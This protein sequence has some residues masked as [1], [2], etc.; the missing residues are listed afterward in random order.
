MTRIVELFELTFDGVTEISKADSI[1]EVTLFQVMKGA[2]SDD[3]CSVNPCTNGGTC[4][5]TWNDYHCECPKGYKGR[6]CSEKEFCHWYRC[7]IEASKCISLTDGYECV[8]NATF[9]G[10][11]STVDYTP[12]FKTDQ[13]VSHSVVA[14]FRTKTNGTVMQVSSGSS[15]IRLT[16]LSSGEMEIE[17]PES[18]DVTR[19]YVYGSSLNN[20]IW[21]TVNVTFGDGGV[22]YATLDGGEPGQLTLDSNVDLI[23]FVGASTV[24]VGASSSTTTGN[25]RDLYE[26]ENQTTVSDIVDI[27]TESLPL[28]RAEQTDNRADHFRGCIGEVRVAGVLLPFF[29]ESE[30]VNSTAGM[31]FI[32]DRISEVSSG[33]CV[34]CYENECQNG[35]F[36]DRPNEVFDCSCAAGFEGSTCG[37]NIDECV[38]SNCL[39]GVC[40]D[41]IANYTCNCLNG[42]TGWL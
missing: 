38:N 22:V 37:G 3:T 12:N 11:N 21:H 23:E 8:T 42:W 17:V 16:V 1:G 35:G 15:H 29:S 2:V 39:K 31:K 4:H 30:L 36:C 14:T 7:P 34:L 33:G 27:R 41:G 9:N 19:A 26:I 28:I 25:D 5:I 18:G 13:V 24:I 20:G 32:A 40:V 6:N 10:V